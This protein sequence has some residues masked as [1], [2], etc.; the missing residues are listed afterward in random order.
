[1]QLA[2]ELMMMVFRTE[3][4]NQIVSNRL[5][6]ALSI[7]DDMPSETVSTVDPAYQW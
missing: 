1:M 5:I 4:L 3:A 7:L 6:A 2:F